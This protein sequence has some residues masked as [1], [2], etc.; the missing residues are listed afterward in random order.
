MSI[1]IFASTS[2]WLSWY[3]EPLVV[4]ILT[5]IA[6]G[7]CYALVRNH[8]QPPQARQPV[9]RARVAAFATGFALLALAL[10]SPLHALG[11]SYLLTAHM[12]QHMLLT[13]VAPPLLLLGLPGWMLAPVFRV[14]WVL[15]VARWLTFPVVAYGL[16]NA[17]IWI[18]HLPPLFDAEAPPVASIGLR[19]V[20]FAVV[21]GSLLIVAL[22]ALPL[23]VTRALAVRAPRRLIR[24]APASARRVGALVSAAGVSVVIALTLVGPLNAV[25]WGP[26]FQPHNPLHLLMV[27]LFFATAILYWTPILSPIPELVPRLSFGAGML[28]MFISTQPMM[29]LGALLTFA[30]QPL[31][32][33]YAGAPLLW[34][35]TRLGDQ[36]FAGLIMWLPM[37]IPLLIALSVLF[38]RWMNHQELTERAAAGEFDEVA[39]PEV[40]VVPKMS[41]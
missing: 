5:A 4:A 12:V 22:V 21:F 7:Y 13:V 23:L 35:F 8:R 16:Y 3:F 18:W 6:G 31:Y 9:E 25:A 26:A 2:L 30:P 10:V 15:R 38:F 24:L 27:A 29:A 36:Q 28:Y 20:D 37:D 33:R 39:E 19:L 14:S 17:T 34:G 40:R 32:S 41:G 11:M 1:P